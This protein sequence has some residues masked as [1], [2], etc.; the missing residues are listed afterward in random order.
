MRSWGCWWC[1][2]SEKCELFLRGSWIPEIA[3]SA[4][5]RAARMEEEYT[6]QYCGRNCTLYV[7]IQAV[8]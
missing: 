1:T 4:V 2:A 3:A 6:A 7:L 5:V 8:F